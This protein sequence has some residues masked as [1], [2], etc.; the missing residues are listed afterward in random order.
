MQYI[1]KMHDVILLYF[2]IYKVAFALLS[3]IYLMFECKQ[4][5]LLFLESFKFERI[6]SVVNIFMT[7]AILSVFFAVVQIALDQVYFQND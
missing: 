6:Y 5:A 1:E 7:S 4:S 2:H 3:P